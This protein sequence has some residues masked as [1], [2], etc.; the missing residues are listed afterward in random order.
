MPDMISFTIRATYSEVRK[1]KVTDD[2][3]AGDIVFEGNLAEDETAP[4]TSCASD[5]GGKS[6]RVICQ[7]SDGAPVA[8][9]VRDG[10][11]VD[12]D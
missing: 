7:R 3:C 10:D 11:V 2:V 4:V 6:G 8:K 1:Y 12:L 5:L 9:D